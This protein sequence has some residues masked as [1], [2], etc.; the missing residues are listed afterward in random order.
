MTL[1]GERYELVADEDP[2]EQLARWMLAP[3]NPYVAQVAVNRLWAEVMGVG[4]VDPVDDF[5][6]TNPASNPELL[7]SLAAYFRQVGFDNKQL[8]KAIF[9]SGVYG[10]SSEPDETNVADH[11]NY[12]R[13]YRKRM[14]AEVLSD[15]I[16]DAIGQAEE[17]EG[18]P[19][20]TRATQ[21][22]THR[23]NS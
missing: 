21:L 6:A 19:P 12:S 14:R 15:A 4:L 1:T 5:R 9:T 7:D 17:F 22:W 16:S 20:G 8:L 11:R 3:D 18:M 2:R 23:L 13:H 10:L